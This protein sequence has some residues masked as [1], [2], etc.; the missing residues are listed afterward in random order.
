MIKPRAIAVCLVA[1][2]WAPFHVIA[3]EQQT[4]TVKISPAPA[5][6]ESRLIVPEPIEPTQPVEL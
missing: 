6:L 4:N 1:T 3:S 2:A 5:E